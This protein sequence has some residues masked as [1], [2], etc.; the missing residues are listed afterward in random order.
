MS[1]V[2]AITYDYVFT[3]RVASFYDKNDFERSDLCEKF[4]EW[5]ATQSQKE[6]ILVW[7]VELEKKEIK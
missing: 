3:A 6:G 4:N 1:S 2:K 5:I 7:S